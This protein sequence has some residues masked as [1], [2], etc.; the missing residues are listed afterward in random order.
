MDDLPKI[1]LWPNLMTAGNL[2]CGFFATLSIFSGMMNPT[3]ASSHFYQAILL[4]LGACVFDAL[5]GRMARLTSQDSPFGRE[6]DSLADIVSFGIA[7]S[8]LVHEIVLAD[9]PDRWGWVISFIYLLCGAM[10]LARF[11]C[12]AAM[13]VKNAS[14]DFVGIPIPAAAGVIASL[15]MLLMWLEA[16][17]RPIGAWKWVLPFLML[18]LAGMMISTIR[19]PSFKGLN[20]R[21]RRSMVWVLVAVLVLVLTAVWWHV[22]PAI[23]FVAYLCYGPARPWISRRWRRELEEED[24]ER[25]REEAEEARTLQ[26]PEDNPPTTAGSPDGVSL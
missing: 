7:P 25:E 11:N 6:F 2:C 21:T 5:D 4:I 9:L 24:E 15:T 23:L 1:Y 22:M 14:R 8:L 20:V 12:L 19:Y 18:L 10:R 16:K 26:A 17:D 3:H 13:D